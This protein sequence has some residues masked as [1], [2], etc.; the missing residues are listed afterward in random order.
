MAFSTGGRGP[1]SGQM[2][3]T[4]LIDVLL[5][6]IIV[7]MVVVSMSKEYVTDAQIPQPAPKNALDL[8]PERTIVIQIEWNQQNR[9]PELKINKE[10]VAWDD[11]GPRLH[12]IYL[13]RLEKVAYVKGD[14]DLDF[15]YVAQVIAEA[16]NAGVERVGLLTKQESF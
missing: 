8:H 13:G 14:D 9:Q 12:L 6:L 4:P 16:H 5:V 7:F 10:V 15:Q 11:L 1:F 3:V 2:N